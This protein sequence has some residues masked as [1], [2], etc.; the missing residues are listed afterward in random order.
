MSAARAER[1]LGAPRGTLLEAPIWSPDT[2]TLSWVD[3]QSG[4][5]F[6]LDPVLGSVTTYET[7]VAPLGA[8]LPRLGGEF[9]LIGGEGVYLWRT[10]AQSVGAPEALFGGGERGLISNDARRDP[11]GRLYV[12]R[13][14]ADESVGAGS[15]VAIEG[16][17]EQRVVATGLTIP[18]G[19]AWSPDGAWLFFAESIEQRVYRV[20]TSAAG[21]RWSERE[22]LI[23]YASELPDGLAIGPDGN[24][25][26]ACYGAGRVDRFSL[27]GDK[28]GEFS[29]PVSQVT[30]CEFVGSNLYVTTAA[31]GFGDD[32]WEREPLAGC[33]FVIRAAIA[34]T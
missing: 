31:E 9:S 12:G 32:D 20:P 13:M 27:S 6:L 8:A 3:I 28:L 34:E 17:G 26:V 24:L 29:L 16:G 25:W 11:W 1:V 23:E 7:G 18:N 22:V 10:D 5:L 14:A 4:R 2:G 15:L 30:A 19:L 21:E 33:M